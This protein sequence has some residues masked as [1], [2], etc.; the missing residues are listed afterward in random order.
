[1]LEA[2][3]M[4]IMHRQLMQ[5]DLLASF[6]SAFNA[7]WHKLVADIGARAVARQR[8]RLAVERKIANLV[9]AVSDGRAS[10]ALL[11][12][13]SELEGVRAALGEAG[14]PPALPATPLGV[15]VAATYAAHISELTQALNRGDDPGGL[16][17]ARGLIDQV[18]IHPVEPG[19]DSGGIEFIGELIELLR[20]AGQGDTGGLCSPARQ[21]PV[22]ELFASSVKEDPGAEP[23]AFLYSMPGSH[24]L[25][26]VRGDPA[27]VGAIMAGHPEA[28]RPSIA[29]GGGHHAG[30]QGEGCREQCRG[31][32]NVTGH[33][34]SP[35]VEM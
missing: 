23:L 32:D 16:E 18:I 20:A 26:A 1:M 2:H 7:D 30:G 35:S 4:D 10:P 8:E 24:A 28:A 33:M 11:A 27:A 12:K 15:G 29:W 14:P 19:D 21:N 25:A 3:V 5:P 9:D 34:R 6:I 17:L 31:E 22:L 13:L